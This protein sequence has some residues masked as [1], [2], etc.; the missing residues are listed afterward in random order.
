MK[1]DQNTCNDT[2]T[3]IKDKLKLY[4]KVNEARS[5]YNIF[6]CL[7]HRESYNKLIA[8]RS[9]SRKT[10]SKTHPYEPLPT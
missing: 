4:S 7:Y 8:C 3:W 2:E 6:S 1:P 5:E 9:F 10:R